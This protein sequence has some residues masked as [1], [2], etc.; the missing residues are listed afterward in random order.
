M[1]MMRTMSETDMTTSMQPSHGI[2]PTR[3]PTLASPAV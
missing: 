1:T 3:L 2:A